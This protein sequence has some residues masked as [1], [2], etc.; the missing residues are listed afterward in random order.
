M[1]WKQLV[2]AAALAIAIPLARA[3]VINGESAPD[4]TLTDINGQTHTLAS[5]QGKMVIL[6]WINHGC[7]FVANQYGTGTMQALQKEARDNGI[8]WLSICSTAPE[9]PDY[10]TPAQWQTTAQEKGGSA[11]AILIDPDGTVGRLYGAK[12]TPHMYIIQQDGTLLYQGAIDDTPSTRPQDI[13]TAKNYV[14]AALGDIAAGR[15]IQT[16]LTKPYGCSVKYP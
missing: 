3:D 2:L 14:R 7:P 10:L 12:T 15:P 6:E 4:F 16:P 8:V 9:K 11:D 13:P 1:T 5:Y